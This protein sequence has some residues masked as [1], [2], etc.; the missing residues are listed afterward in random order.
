[1]PL[2]VIEHWTVPPAESVPPDSTRTDVAFSKLLTDALAPDGTVSVPLSVSDPAPAEHPDSSVSVPVT[3]NDPTL[4]DPWQVRSF[5][6]SEG[7][8]SWVKGP[9]EVSVAKG[10]LPELSCSEPPLVIDSTV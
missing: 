7:T 6:V 2:F 8:P 10:L 1:M 5:N 4:K 3:V 9:T